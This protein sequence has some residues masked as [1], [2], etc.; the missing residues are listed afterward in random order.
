MPY[1]PDL[2]LVNANVLTMDPAR[3]RATAVAVAGGRIVA[4]GDDAPDLAS[5]VAA[6]NVVNLRGATLVPGFHDAHNHMI[7]FGL[8][9][10]EIDLRVDALDELYARVAAKAAATPAGEWIVGA[11]YDQTKTGAHPHRDALDRI[12]PGHRV[13]LKHTSGHMCAV[14]S[15]VLRDLGI[16]AA[17]ADVDGGRVAADAS[18]RP[19]GLMEERAQQLVG[20]LTHPYPL[21]TLTDA[22]AAAGEHY[23]REGL[24]SV[25]EAGVGGGWIGQSPDELAAYVTARDQGRLHVR[26]EL[27]V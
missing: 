14:N 11:G 8:S 7:G 18:G 12:A 6:E 17:A 10:T 20:N 22:V 25:T 23:V 24:T 4:V 27:M 16:D 2:L 1:A 15:L 26:A 21:S 13:W 19:T 3:P 5:G 9:L